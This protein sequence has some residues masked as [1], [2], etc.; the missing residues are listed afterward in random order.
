[1][2]YLFYKAA[3]VFQ[4]KFRGRSRTHRLTLL[5]SR[6]GAVERNFVFRRILFTCYIFALTYLELDAT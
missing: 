4:D 2:A 6:S 3:I 1:M 5:S